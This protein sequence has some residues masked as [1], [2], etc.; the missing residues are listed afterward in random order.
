MKNIKE[1][2][3]EYNKEVEFPFLGNTLIIPK[4]R[5]IN[6]QLR[7]KYKSI[8]DR[9][10][11]D[12]AKRLKEY[13]DP[14][15]L[16]E[17][18]AEDFLYS[19]KEGLDEIAKDAI[20]VDCYTFDMEAVSKLCIKKGY[21]N[22]YDKAVSDYKTGYITILKSNLSDASNVYDKASNH[23]TLEVKTIGGSLA[24]VAANQMEADFTN[25]FIGELYEMGAAL[26]V[27]DIADKSDRE[28]A[29]YFMDPA[30]KNKII[31]SVWECA[32]NLRLVISN[33]LNDECNLGLAGW[34]T[35]DDSTKAESMYNNL[36]SI[37]LTEEK[38]KE[39]SLSILKLNPYK[40]EYYNTFLTKY[41]D[42]AKEILAIADFFG[43][44][45][46]AYTQK[47]MKDFAEQNV[48]SSF[49]DIKRIRQIVRDKIDE[50]GFPDGSDSL[51]E[52][53]LQSQGAD[54]FSK[55]LA[56]NLGETRSEVLTCFDK[57]R[58][59]A[60][61]IGFGEKYY[62]IAYKPFTDKMDKL[63][64]ELIEELTRWI[65]ENIG[66]TEEDA[67]KCRNDLDKRIEAE[68][69]DRD[70][71]N[72]LYK[73]IDDRLKNLDDEYR[74]IE[75]FVFPTRESA[76]E[77]KA[78]INENKD[79][80]YKKSSDFIYRDDFIAHIE[81]IKNVPLIEKLTL[82]FV[83]IYEK[84][85][86][87]FDKKCKNA[88][89]YDDKINGQKKNLI[90]L[91]RSVVV[92]EKIQQRNWNEVTRNG[93]YT[94][95]DIL[96]IHSNE[97]TS[98]N[99][100]TLNNVNAD[101]GAN[102]DPIKD[103]INRIIT[104]D[105]GPDG[106]NS[107]KDK[108]KSGAGMLAGA[109]GKVG[110][111]AKNAAG[112]AVDYAKSGEVK[113]RLNSVKNKAKSLTEKVQIVDNEA[114]SND[115]NPVTEINEN[116]SSNN[117]Q[118]NHS[119]TEN[120]SYSEAS[121]AV[122]DTVLKEQATDTYEN[123]Y[124]PE[125]YAVPATS[126]NTDTVVLPDSTPLEEQ[127]SAPQNTNN[128]LINQSY[129]PKP[130]RPASTQNTDNH[131]TYS[132]AHDTSY[133][134]QNTTPPMQYQN[135][136]PEPQNNFN[137]PPPV[138]PQ[139]GFQ[140]ISEPKKSNTVAI[141]LAIIAAL[142]LGIAVIG[143]LFLTKEKNP[144]P[145]NDNSVS[146]V[147]TTEVSSVNEETTVETTEEKAETTEKTD[148]NSSVSDEEFNAD[149]E[150]FLNSLVSDSSDPIKNAKYALF[151]VNDDGVKELFF[152][153]EHM[154]GIYTTMYLYDNNTFNATDVTGENVRICTNESL[155]ECDRF[156]GGA[157][158]AYYSISGDNI[159]LADKLYSY[160]GQYYHGDA[161]IT[162]S[163]FNSLLAEKNKLSWLEPSFTDYTPKNQG[164]ANSGSNSIDYHSDHRSGAGSDF[165]FAENDGAGGLI[166]TESDALNLR[167]KPDVNAEI[168][169]KMPKDSSVGIFGS[170]SD[171]YYIH[172][173]EN[174]T[175]YYGYA[176]RQYVRN[177]Q[178]EAKTGI[179]P[180]EQYGTI[181]SPSGAKVDG[182]ARSYI[183]DGGPESYIRHDLTHGWH[184][185][186]V[187]KYS[188][189][190]VE[191]YELYDADDGDYYGWV[192]NQSI[193]FY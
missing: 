23:P 134:R 138:Q 28:V 34:V 186:A 161:I 58:E 150:K 130:N 128:N 11:K 2:I 43:M 18:V 144:K 137:T 9:A 164:I 79:I 27:A 15:A 13:K 145:T 68:F 4:E 49:D 105:D 19:M 99:N 129:E 158:Y 124:I 109:V 26:K 155:I 110:D 84:K 82:Y 78:I 143:L 147:I 178:V 37:Q 126:D 135:Y 97:R 141:L 192:S 171:W 156:G 193:S 190:T 63:D 101:T 71:A 133:Q 122:E 103:R 56:Q 119:E 149:V 90:N 160:A 104:G 159:N 132:Q 127:Y 76:E 181:Y 7:M 44:N 30:P 25:A 92:P 75:G 152:T 20:S 174:G 48:V 154:A 140:R 47:I 46:S 6:N 31:Q 113:E 139:S 153:A 94:L 24:D 170:N 62:D 83:Y 1:I 151:D 182:Y 8:A 117:T 142:L 65:D 59:L 17:G 131:G 29:R 10:K 32:F 123:A 21:F 96:G 107:L 40:Y 81:K 157:V 51:A 88:K 55:Y 50:L 184:I 33:Q 36:K 89:L 163:E 191:W 95:N 118:N 53:Y 125:S 189:N 72:A 100:S 86:K 22:S 148:N 187:N 64:T 179:V 73:K 87:E 69:L 106:M 185:K 16:I 162:E 12:F 169:A 168:I 108:A 70:K 5:N 67:K 136:S 45:L 114:A 60:D 61:D 120:T 98:P 116:S 167:A 42:N 41:L 85:L 115:D 111:A 74:I 188:T 172:Y 91:V 39:L 173:T 146:A 176:S 80:L 112:N 175:S 35:K 183:I 14:K 93:K 121:G 77:T 54:L 177:L 180:I 102:E 66:T 165:V 166:A 38:E 57:S 3:V 52:D